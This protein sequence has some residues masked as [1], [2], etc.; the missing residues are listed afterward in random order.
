[1]SCSEKETFLAITKSAVALV[2]EID[3]CPIFSTVGVK[4]PYA[5]Q[6]IHVPAQDAVVSAA[7]N[8]T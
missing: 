2:P 7:K 5:G 4:C 6:G 3:I 8:E 1:M